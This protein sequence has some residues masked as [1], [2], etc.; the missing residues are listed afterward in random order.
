M[1]LTL[2]QDSVYFDRM[3][4]SLGDKGRILDYLVDGSA[5]DVGAGGGELSETMR[6]AGHD[7]TAMDGS[8]VAVARINE[9]YPDVSTVEAMTD[10]MVSGQVDVG[11]FDNVVCSSVLHEV[12]S[13]GV[14]KDS[15]V[16]SVDS[17][18]DSLKSFFNVL[19]SGGRLV[20]R[21]GVMPELWDEEVTVRLRTDDAVRFL[22]LYRDLSPFY[23]DCGS[24]RK[25]SL[26]EAGYDNQ[27]K[28]YSCSLG[29]AMEFLYT[30]TWG[31]GSAERE[32]QELYGVFTRKEYEKALEAVGFKIVESFEYVQSGYIEHLEPLTDI[33]TANGSSHDWPSSNMFIVAEKP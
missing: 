33:I 12:Y 25:V 22:G 11:L 17:V 18:L 28:L 4:A 31:F 13:Y 27:G 9:N 7:V 16:G 2:S 15:T 14:N 1:M 21:D 8:S 23:S 10:D 19:V 32:T 24:Y 26:T 29:S 30:L 20:I 3:A 6:L 5:L